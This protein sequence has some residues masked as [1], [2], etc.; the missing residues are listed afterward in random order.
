MIENICIRFLIIF[1]YRRL[2]NEF[3]IQAIHRAY[4]SPNPQIG[5]GLV[6]DNGALAITVTSINRNST[7]EKAPPVCTMCICVWRNF[8][9]VRFRVRTTIC[10]DDE[11][12]TLWTMWRRIFSDE[13]GSL[14]AKR[15]YLISA[16]RRMFSS[17]AKLF[18]YISWREAVIPRS[19]SARKTK[20]QSENSFESSDDD[21]GNDDDFGRPEASDK[22]R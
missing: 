10:R 13:L 5:L 6:D 14:S 7:D 16:T 8:F 17:F 22:L 15:K 19:S 12:G 9:H 1:S 4:A 11:S 21:D 20:G 3:N 18:C 2:N